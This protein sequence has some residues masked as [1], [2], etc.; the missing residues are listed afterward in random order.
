MN[1]SPHWRARLAADPLPALLEWPDEALRFF[2]RRDLAGGAA[3]N[4][5]SLW[6]LPDAVR[7]A[8]K[9]R[10]DGAW[11]YPG[12]RAV[13][14]TRQNY[15]LLETYRSLRMLVEM[16]G[17]TRAH[18]ALQKAA[19][20][21]F[22]CQTTEGDIRGILGNQYAPYYHGAILELLIKAGYVEDA[23]VRA[24]L[25][26]LLAMRQGDGGWMVP[27]QAVPPS[28]RTPAFWS[29]QP[30]PPD[31]ARPHAHLSTGMALRAFAAHPLYRRRA[32]VLAAGRCLEERLF[33]ADKYNDRRAPAYWL[34][35]QFPF[36]WPNLL[37]ALDTLSGLGFGRRQANIARG[38]AWF[39][40]HQATDGL[41]PTGYGAGSKAET[42]RRWVG[43]AVCRV[44]KRFSSGST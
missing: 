41:W 38:L 17:F 27:A 25:D 40:N 23:P 4:V 2:V 26:W 42:N 32:E 36:W 20:Y 6:A 7:L 10:P 16:Y 43:L 11:D 18:P 28:Q 30:M 44:L 21:V 29:G 31:R 9:Q 37:T 19:E 14:P 12:K 15:R 1:Q 5:E 33:Q 22:S 35:F 39:A 8:S 24:G 13:P 3:G 34:K